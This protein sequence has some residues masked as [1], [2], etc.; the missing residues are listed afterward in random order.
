MISLISLKSFERRR[1]LVLYK[2]LKTIKNTS[3]I[4]LDL[5]ARQLFQYHVNFHCKF[6]ILHGTVLGPTQFIIY[7]IPLIK[8]LN[9]EVTVLTC[10]WYSFLPFY[11]WYVEWGKIGTSY[12]A[13]IMDST[14]LSKSR[15]FAFSLTEKIKYIIV[16][17]SIKKVCNPKSNPPGY[18]RFSS[19][20]T[21]HTVV[22]YY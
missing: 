8:K 3:G 10:K 7:I 19:A 16:I 15:Y 4:F 9:V 14:N 18:G 2:I 5:P 21:F 17:I 6:V 20:T 22:S 13:L 1:N 11:K 12:I